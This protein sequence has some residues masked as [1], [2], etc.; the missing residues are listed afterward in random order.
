M[1]NIPAG[2]VVEKTYIEVIYYVF[3]PLRKSV[4]ATEQIQCWAHLKALEKL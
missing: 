4:V 1:R 3:L 2:D